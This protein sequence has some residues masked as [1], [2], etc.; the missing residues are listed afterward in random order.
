MKFLNSIDGASKIITDSNHQ[1][2]TSAQKAELH[3]HPNST[4]LNNITEVNGELRY[5]GET[6]VTKTV[7]TWA[8]LKGA[9][10]WGDLIGL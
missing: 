6:V 4:V 8:R 7:F 5:N 3:T 1:F 2:I 9:M 10:S